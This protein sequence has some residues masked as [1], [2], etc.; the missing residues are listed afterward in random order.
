V[1]KILL[2][3]GP[4]N[5]RFMTKF[6]QWLGS[7]VCHRTE[8]FDNALMLV[9]ELLL[10]KFGDMTKEVAIMGGSGTTAME[11][12][13]ASLVPPGTTIINAGAY[14]SRAI[15]IT[16]TYF[17]HCEEVECQNI[18]ELKCDY[19]VKFVYFVENETSTG[20]KFS[21]H[22]MAEIYPYAKFFID[23]TSAFGASKYEHYF[24]RIAAISFCS[25]KCL[26]ST[27]GLGIVMWDGDLQDYERC[28][29]G[30]LSKYG[31]E[32]MPFTLPV[33]SVYALLSALKSEEN[34]EILFSK[35]RDKIIKALS[36]FGIECI[37]KHP[38]NSII[39]FR[40]PWMSCD[41]LKG[42]L[43]KRGIIIYSGVSG[44]EN[45]FKLSTMSVKFDSKFNK[46]VKALYDSCVC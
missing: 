38:S 41:K 22:R 28:Y 30:G 36:K 4:T 6:K 20:E 31:F 2:N 45:S 7:D 8:E 12:M 29:Y 32:K 3:P 35:R 19:S 33:Q 42:F 15:D 43:D 27:P 10:K 5:T 23:A 44:V 24:D 40:H 37:N 26:Q 9:Q 1:A 46:I 25:N 39:G 13:I 17:I 18:D 14:G 11:S 16:K 34:N 21:L